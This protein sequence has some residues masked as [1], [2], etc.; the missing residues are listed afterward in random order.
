MGREGIGSEGDLRLTIMYEVWG[1][2]RIPAPGPQ[3][4]HN[5][6]PPANLH[7]PRKSFTKSIA[8]FL[9]RPGAASM[10]TIC[11]VL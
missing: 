9:N 8:M 6:V 3:I 2:N 11:T 1:M 10:T 5:G 7:T 4:K